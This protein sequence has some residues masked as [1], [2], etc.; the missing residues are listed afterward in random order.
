MLNSVVSAEL[1]LR[2]NRLDMVNVVDTMVIVVAVVDTVVITMDGVVI[3]VGVVD[4]VEES[5]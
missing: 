3:A 2:R 5:R 1:T 4:M